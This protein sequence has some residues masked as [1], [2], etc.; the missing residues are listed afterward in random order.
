MASG[1]FPA[2]S[3]SLIRHLKDTQTAERQRHLQRLIALYWEPVYWVIRQHWNRGDD[4]ARDL[5]QQFFT[6]TVLEGTL[7]NNFAP[8]R[9]SFRAFVCGAIAH[10][11]IDDIRAA[12]AQKRGGGV[13]TLSLDGAG[14]ELA[15]AVPV[16]QRTTPEEVFD[17]A[18]TRIVFLRATKLLGERLEAE[19]KTGSFEIFQSY[20][21]ATGAAPSY[22]SVAEALGLTVDQVKHGLVEARAVFRDIVTEIVRS[23]VDGPEELAREL[24]RLLGG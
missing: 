3:W 1:A 17:A 14:L 13:R 20:D 22:K 6:T 7:L 11:I 19:G 15:S 2:T 12:E 23:Y 24:R 4:D 18:W 8:N 10:F 5:T 21:L 9:G 16:G